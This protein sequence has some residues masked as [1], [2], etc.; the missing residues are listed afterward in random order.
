MRW[1]SIRNPSGELALTVAGNGDEVND[2]VEELLSK[3]G[4]SWHTLPTAHVLPSAVSD[5]L[6]ITSCGLANVS[7]RLLYVPAV[8]L[9]V[10]KNAESACNCVTS[11]WM[12]V[13][14]LSSETGEPVVGVR[15]ASVKLT[16]KKRTET[17]AGGSSV[18]VI[19]TGTVPAD[20]VT[21]VFI[22]ILELH[23]A[24]RAVIMPVKKK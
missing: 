1:K 9:A 13:L 2:S 7:L 18:M 10:L 24:S 23:P 12:G 6:K 4:V 19:E 22:T 17:P 3:V 16:W 11:I 21:A 8:T 15:V 14:L 20:C 5:W